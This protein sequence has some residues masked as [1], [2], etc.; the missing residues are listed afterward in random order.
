MIIF[1]LSNYCE[2]QIS[3]NSIVCVALNAIRPSLFSSFIYS[4][5][6]QKQKCGFIRNSK[7]KIHQTSWMQNAS[8]IFRFFLTHSSTCCSSHPNS[9]PFTSKFNTYKHTHTLNNHYR[10]NVKNWN[11]IAFKNFFVLKKILW[12]YYPNFVFI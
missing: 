11:S 4:H 12:L 3:F 7:K 8:I 10:V 5:M 2:H 1:S 6:L 9:L